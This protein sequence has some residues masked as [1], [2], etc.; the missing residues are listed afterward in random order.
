MHAMPDRLR[1]AVIGA[2]HFGRYHA[3]KYAA[4][5]TAALVAV[6]DLDAAAAGRVAAECGT[7]AVDD[8]RTLFGKVDA[9][10]VAVPTSR[11]REVAGACLEQGIAVLVEKPIAA[12]LEE[13]EELIALAAAHGATLQVGHLE[14]FSPAYFAM[15]DA[16]TTPLYIEADRISPYNPRAT[17]VSVVLDLMIHDIDLIAAL[18]GQPVERVDAIGAPVVSKSEDIVNTRVTFASGCVANL[19][20]SRVSLKTE[21]TMRIFEPECYVQADLAKRAVVIR[22][23][24]EGEMFPG[25]P[26]IEEERHEFG[27]ADSLAL[28][29]GA[30]VEAVRTGAPV[31]VSGEAGRDAVR[32]AQMITESLQAHRRRL[33]QSG[34]I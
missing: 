9:V 23:R 3:Q 21:R 32:A 6:C 4:L 16:V 30:F 18:V 1:C 14:R 15:A 17:D 5:E 27:E 34:L 13:A 7:E 29:I 31:A 33:E 26:N 22:R 10:S 24:G 11:H 20:A 25:I 12:T 19:T 8:F 28:E 2:G